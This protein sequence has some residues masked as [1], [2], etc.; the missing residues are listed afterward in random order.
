[1]EIGTNFKFSGPEV[2]TLRRVAAPLLAA[3]LGLI[4]FPL[5]ANAAWSF[6]CPVYQPCHWLLT[7]GGASPAVPPGQEMYFPGEA[8][9][10]PCAYRQ[11]SPQPDP[12]S[13]AWQGHDPEHGRL[14]Q[15]WCPD[16]LYLE[17]SNPDGTNRQADTYIGTYYVP[18]GAPP[19]ASPGIDPMAL[20][21]QA[22]GNLTIPPPV[23]HFG[24]DATQ[25]AVKV[26]TWLWIDDAGPIVQTASAGTLTAT[27]T[28]TL[29]SS[30]WQMGEPMDVARPSDHAPTVSCQGAGRPYRAGSS[31]AAAPCQ[32]TYVWRSLP[33]RT[34]GTGTWTVTVTANWTVGWTVSS[35]EAGS[36]QVTVTG[37]A[38]LQVREWHVVLVDKPVG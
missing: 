32:Y 35:G 33:D 1:M 36:E 31:P 24:P 20:V 21:A 17:I 22:M 7:D 5:I 38:P 30:E 26:P 12:S 11:L 13:A 29:V 8:D 15:T 25:V 14:W 3:S 2:L 10:D 28:A 37:T 18:D 19:G 6:A 9:P 16:A 23:P 34:G 27:V 4:A